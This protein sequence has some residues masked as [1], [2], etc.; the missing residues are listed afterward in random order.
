M[1]EFCTSHFKDH[2]GCMFQIIK[3]MC[4]YDHQGH[5]CFK[6]SRSCMFMI[7]KVMYVYDHQ[8]CMFQKKGCKKLKIQKEFKKLKKHE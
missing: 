8:G 2:Q 3:V 1:F 7:I 4:V 6:S 5:V